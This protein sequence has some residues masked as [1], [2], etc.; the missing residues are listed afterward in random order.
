MTA[1]TR[2]GRAGRAARRRGR[3]RPRSI[4]AHRRPAPVH[5]ARGAVAPGGPAGR[6]GPPGHPLRRSTSAAISS[7]GRPSVCTSRSPTPARSMIRSSS[8]AR[9]RC[10]A[11]SSPYSRPR[12][13]TRGS[14]CW[15]AAPHHH[16]LGAGNHRAVAVD[17]LPELHDVRQHQ[18]L[19]P[20]SPNMSRTGGQVAQ[21]ETR[22][23]NGSS[24]G[25]GLPPQ[26]V[27]AVEAEAKPGV[28]ARPT[29]RRRP[30][31]RSVFPTPTGPVST[32][33]GTRAPIITP[34]VS[35]NRAHPRLA[36][37]PDC[38]L[39]ADGPQPSPSGSSD[40]PL[41]VSVSAA[42]RVRRQPVASRA[43]GRQYGALAAS[44]TSTPP[45]TA[46]ARRGA[47]QSQPGEAVKMGS[48]PAAPVLASD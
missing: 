33:T 4:P 22:S 44:R 40:L 12:S 21:A 42:R 31:R 25:V 3:R 27:P 8:G 20:A 17:L 43:A 23:P 45:S 2:K 16:D 1:L 37:T 39:V 9:R 38:G 11:R 13:S 26:R 48:P 28:C 46:A 5:R 41:V 30:S 18:P 15:P 6:G 35:S 24:G 32:S 19:V 7:T 10:H 34:S 47:A 36:P 29:A 14:P